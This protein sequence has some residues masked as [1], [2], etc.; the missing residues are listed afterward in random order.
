MYLYLCIE[1]LHKNPVIPWV[2]P[3]AEELKIMLPKICVQIVQHIHTITSNS[4]SIFP[5]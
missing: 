5:K 4:Y 1:I 2:T 3:Y